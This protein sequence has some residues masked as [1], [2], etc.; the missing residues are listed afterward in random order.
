MGTSRGLRKF[1]TKWPKLWCLHLFY[2]RVVLASFDVAPI[3]SP[4]WRR[5]RG[6]GV[7]A[8]IRA[9]RGLN[10]GTESE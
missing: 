2:S 5:A 3:T 9:Q 10:P 4:T 7:W 8:R 6:R 1:S